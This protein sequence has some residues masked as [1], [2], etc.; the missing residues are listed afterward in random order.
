MPIAPGFP[1]P[2]CQ[3]QIP[4]SLSDL[5]SRQSLQCPF[6]GLQLQLVAEQSSAA[7]ELASTALNQIQHT[8]QDWQQQHAAVLNPTPTRHSRRA[9]T[10]RRSNSA[11]KTRSNSDDNEQH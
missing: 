2:Q 1:C 8:G 11:T 6:C 7:L 9:R 5:L 3:H 4:V 10:S